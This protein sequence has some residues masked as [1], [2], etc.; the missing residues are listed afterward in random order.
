MSYRASPSYALGG[1]LW[2]PETDTNDV[3]PWGWRC[4]HCGEHFPP[5]QWLQARQ[6]FGKTSTKPPACQVAA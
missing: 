2:D 1:I 6:H 5:E 4:F 3:P